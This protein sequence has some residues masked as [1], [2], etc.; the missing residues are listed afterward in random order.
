[1]V[2][3]VQVRNQRD[4]DPVVASDTV[5]TTDDDA[6]FPRTAMPQLEWRFSADTRQIDRTMARASKS[7]I[8]TVRFFQQKRCLP[9]SI[10]TCQGQKQR[11]AENK[12]LAIRRHG[13]PIPAILSNPNF[14]AEFRN[15]VSYWTLVIP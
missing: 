13:T 8:V 7:A 2:N 15:L 3:R 6:L 14:D 4:G 12:R 5:V 9:P 11:Q 1:M 10:R